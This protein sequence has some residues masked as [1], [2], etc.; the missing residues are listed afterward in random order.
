MTG[1]ERPFL[2]L[3]GGGGRVSYI[4]FL[5]SGGGRYIAATKGEGR[6]V[7]KR[8][9]THHLFNCSKDLMMSAS[10]KP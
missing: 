6:I 3:E 8:G 4:T 10:Q 1:R 5:K 7:R 2:S 9:E